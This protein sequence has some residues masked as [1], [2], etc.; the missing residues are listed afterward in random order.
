MAAMLADEEQSAWADAV[1]L[2]FPNQNGRGTHVNISGA[3][4]TKYA[5]NRDNAVKL[6]E[7]LTG[8]FG[9]RLYAEQNNEYPVRAGAPWSALLES[10]GR[11]KTDS[12]SLTKIAENRAEAIKVFD[13]VGIP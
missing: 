5:P 13:R 8:E 12:L 9:Q 7:F 2:V 11:F 3:G 4:V 6:L 1:Y 10:W